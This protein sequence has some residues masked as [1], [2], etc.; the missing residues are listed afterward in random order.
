MKTKVIINGGQAQIV[1]GEGQVLA[2]L[3]ALQG[4]KGVS[5]QGESTNPEAC[6]VVYAQAGGGQGGG[7]EDR[8]GQ[9]QIMQ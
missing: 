2:T 9:T 4:E 1:G 8:T 7:G 6:E 5:I 3:S